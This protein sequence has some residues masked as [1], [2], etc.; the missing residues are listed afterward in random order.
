MSSVDSQV[1][2]HQGKGGGFQVA[3][4]R[5]LSRSRDRLEIPSIAKHGR[6]IWPS[7]PL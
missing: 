1:M 6:S 3:C 7:V 4:K 2:H 5:E